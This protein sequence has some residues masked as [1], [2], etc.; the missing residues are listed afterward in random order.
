MSLWCTWGTAVSLS[1]L[2][3]VS[4]SVCLSSL[5]VPSSYFQALPKSHVRWV[6][7]Q[8]LDCCHVHLTAGWAQKHY[9]KLV[10]CTN[11]LS[12]F[13]WKSK[14][15]KT[16]GRWCWAEVSGRLTEGYEGILEQWECSSL[17]VP[18]HNL[19]THLFFSCLDL[20]PQE[21]ESIPRQ[22]LSAPGSFIHRIPKLKLSVPTREWVNEQT[23]LMVSI[24]D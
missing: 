17:R 19:F 21:R 7:N 9:A 20:K 11:K 1:I 8:T 10:R 15:G 5:S 12:P 16:V 23:N 6:L 3:S 24:S 18:S 22:R 2:V 4:H 14:E 13:I